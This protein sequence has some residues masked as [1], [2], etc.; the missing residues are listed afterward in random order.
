MAIVLGVFVEGPKTQL[1]MAVDMIWWV[2][3]GF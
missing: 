2:V 1:L 3:V